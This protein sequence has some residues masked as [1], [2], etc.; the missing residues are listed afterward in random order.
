M[1]LPQLANT[2]HSQAGNLRQLAAPCMTMTEY[3]TIL[4]VC[5]LLR[6]GERTVYAMCRG[7]ELPGSA[8][9]GNQWRVERAKLIAW[10]DEGG[11]AKTQKRSESR[12]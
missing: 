2:H 9:V 12:R 11:A 3:M 8:K 10:L 6:L 1:I 5:E 7:G 4:E